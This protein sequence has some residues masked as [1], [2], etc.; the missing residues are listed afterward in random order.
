MKPPGQTIDQQRI[1]AYCIL[2]DSHDRTGRTR[3][4]DVEG[5]LP[6]PAGLAISPDPDTRD[7]CFLFYCDDNWAVIADTWHASVPDAKAQAEFEFGGTIDE[8]QTP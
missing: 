2:A 4:L 3:H 5:T 1:L 8:W 7:A 6:S